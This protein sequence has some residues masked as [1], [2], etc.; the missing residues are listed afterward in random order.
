MY[1][2]LLTLFWGCPLAKIKCEFE[3][4]GLGSEQEQLIFSVVRERKGGLFIYYKKIL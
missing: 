3:L 2:F 4:E 1:L